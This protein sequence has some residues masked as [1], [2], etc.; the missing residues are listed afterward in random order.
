MTWQQWRDWTK[1]ARDRTPW[2]QVLLTLPPGCEGASKIEVMEKDGLDAIIRE[3]A[4]NQKRWPRMTRIQRALLYYRC[5]RAMTILNSLCAS[6]VPA[7][8]GVPFHRMVE[9][10]LIDHWFWVGWSAWKDYQNQVWL[11]RQLDI[12]V[13]IPERPEDGFA[14]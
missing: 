13:P 5:E 1:K 7:P 6:P 8:D 12:D 14:S 10:L 2:S 3:Y 11:C 9:W 4:T